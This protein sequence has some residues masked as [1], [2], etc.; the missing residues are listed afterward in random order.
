MV[1]R[2]NVHCAGRCTVLVRWVGDNRSRGSNSGG[3]RYIGVR[4]V[5]LLSWGSNYDRLLVSGLG[6]GGY[7]RDC[8]ASARVGASSR[9]ADDSTDDSEQY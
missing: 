8:G 9:S 7:D 2:R 3:G 5:S 1:V 4:R 6:L